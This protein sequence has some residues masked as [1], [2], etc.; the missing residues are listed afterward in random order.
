METKTAD[1]P[2]RAEF[3]ISNTKVNGV[4][5]SDGHVPE[6]NDEA[7]S[8]YIR[9]LGI[10]REYAPTPGYDHYQCYVEFKRSDTFKGMR[11]NQLADLLGVD[12]C[13]LNY[14]DFTRNRD[15]CHEYFLKEETTIEEARIWGTWITDTQGGRPKEE[16]PTKSTYKDALNK[17][18]EGGITRSELVEMKAE[19]PTRTKQMDDTLS[20][21]LADEERV[22]PRIHW[23][24]SVD[25]ADIGE[26]TAMV[27]G[28]AEEKAGE[29]EDIYQG[30]EYSLYDHRFENYVGEHVVV[31]DGLTPE[32]DQR[33]VERTSAF[34]TKLLTN[35][36]GY[37]VRNSTLTTIPFRAYDIYIVATQ[38]IKEFFKH[39]KKP[40]KQEEALT[41]YAEYRGDMVLKYIKPDN[42]PKKIV[43]PKKTSEAVSRAK[44]SHS[45]E[46]GSDV[47]V[48]SNVSAPTIANIKA[49][50]GEQQEQENKKKEAMTQWRKDALKNLLDL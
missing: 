7:F 4:D 24:Y 15:V 5:Y 32:R 17:I 46:S 31:L 27:E 23:F 25:I 21:S 3:I 36:N 29:L 9:Y 13:R 50:T 43:K 42:K 16:K 12:R 8:P 49:L 33:R 28:I 18:K 41:T 19:H 39:S 47:S 35:K 20:I 22:L 26:L 45:S 38:P 44:A 1:K 40:E 10:K 48:R 30:H 14:A 11:A 6:F 37:S 2:N 34:I